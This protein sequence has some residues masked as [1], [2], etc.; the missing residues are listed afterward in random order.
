MMRY[1]FLNRSILSK[2]FVLIILVFLPEILVAETAKVG[3]IAPLTGQLAEYG[4]ATR[5]GFELARKNNPDI[6]KKVD[7]VFEDSQYDPK[8]A[9][10]IYR[11]FREDK[12]IKII[13]NWGSNPSAPLI[14]IAE[15]ECFPLVT[16]DFSLTQ[17]I[18]RK[19]VMGF[20]NSTLDLGNS[21]A[22]QLKSN[23]AK[24]IAIVK[25]ENSYINGML[26]GLKQGLGPQATLD[27]VATFEPSARSST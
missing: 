14:P 22:T 5:N 4:V 8:L 12:D 2:F 25:V 16:M 7:F 11:K 3:V 9:L 15:L 10:G 13:F 27:V 26:E 18:A 24:R 1:Y 19:C 23:S 21:L 6:F 20:V 17:P